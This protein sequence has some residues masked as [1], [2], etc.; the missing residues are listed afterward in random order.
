MNGVYANCIY[1]KKYIGSKRQ[2]NSQKLF[3]K[4]KIIHMY[5][6]YLQ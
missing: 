6:E 1:E 2:Q 4:I 3:K 5:S